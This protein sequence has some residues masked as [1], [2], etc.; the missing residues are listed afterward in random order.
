MCFVCERRESIYI[1]IAFVIVVCMWQVCRIRKVLCVVRERREGVHVVCE[2]RERICVVMK[3]GRVYMWFMC[4]CLISPA[5]RV[6]RNCDDDGDGDD[7]GS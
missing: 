3:G 6:A 1:P 2:M 7:V 4:A 5:T